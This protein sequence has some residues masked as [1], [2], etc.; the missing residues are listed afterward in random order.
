MSDSNGRTPHS[1]HESL[2]ELF[3]IELELPTCSSKNN[4]EVMA[5]AAYMTFIFS[6]L[7]YKQLIFYRELISHIGLTSDY[8]AKNMLRILAKNHGGMQL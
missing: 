7:L 2:G 5:T 8:K 6:Q 3:G 1:R 4:M